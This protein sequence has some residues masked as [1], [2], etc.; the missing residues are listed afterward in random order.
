MKYRMILLAMMLSMII[1]FPM[2]LNAYATNGPKIDILRQIVIRTPTA[3]RIAMLAG[4]ADMSPD[5]IQTTDIEAQAK[6]PDGIPGTA[7]DM[8]ITEDLGFHMGF[9]AYNI[10]DTATINEIREI[11]GLPAVSYWP[12]HDVAFRHA[13]I[14]SYDQLPIVAT[15]YGYVVTPVRSL[16]PPAQSKYYNSAVPT[17]PFNQG[18]PITS[19]AGEHS[20]CGILKAAGYTFV[21]AGTIGVVDDHDK[22]KMPNGD[23]LPKMVIW[24][25][26][27]TD[28]PTSFN[29][30][31]RFVAD[32]AN[33][34]L[35]ASSNNGWAGMINE[36]KDFNTYLDL[37]YGTGTSPGGQH[38][39]Y[40]VFYSLSRLPSQLYSCLHTDMDAYTN[41]GQN[42]GPGVNDAV[43]D[44]LTETVRFSLDTDDIEAAAKEVQNML[45]T[46]DKTVYP[47]ADNFAL[48]YM[49][50]YSRS[51]FNVF[52]TNVVNGVVRS[53]GYGADSGWTFLNVES[54]REE[55][56][57]SV[58]IYINGL[59]PA[60]LNPTFSTTAYEWNILNRLYDGL[61]DVNPYNHY[62][63]PW[64]ATDWSIAETAGGMTVDFTMRDDVYWQ[65]GYHVT[66]A[67]VKFCLEALRDYGSINWADAA[68]KL[69]DVTVTGTYSLTLEASEAGL[70][71]FY[72][73]SGG[74]LVLPPQIWDRAWGVGNLITSY[75]PSEHDYGTDMA[76]GYST[77]PWASSVPTNLFGSG[78]FIFRFYDATNEFDDEWANRNYFMTQTAVDALMADMFWEVG[79]YNKDGIVNVVDL[80][81][82][83][84]AFGCIEGLDPC[85]DAPRD[86]NSDGIIDIKD[87]SNCAFHLLWQ[88]T[89]P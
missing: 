14:H 40:M 53:P 80:T 89:Y 38:D 73:Y 20:T 63:I 8:L 12:L 85:Y 44:D 82:V 32:L 18:N 22:W 45:Y 55:D 41:W 76:P 21:D 7:D 50:L 84:L 25:P 87:M 78:P 71:L 62:D 83:S 2:T 52:S 49:L 6:G 15:I 28:A 61:T 23:P 59:P 24:T 42:N 67:D 1:I 13:L 36:G 26:L 68:S 16:V 43:I 4:Q 9:I 86:F 79:D 46:P 33:V 17:H 56:G 77:G 69:I 54:T 72:D 37:V 60:T 48:A 27:S 10:R 5:Q 65:D 35:A 70:S 31:A 34:G 51:Y 29:H 47:N 58:L 75:A 64:I 88:R 74:A 57:K 19:P 11:R 81:F 66:A 30:G 3:S 39:A